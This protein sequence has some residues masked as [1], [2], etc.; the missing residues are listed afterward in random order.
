MLPLKS[1]SPRFLNIARR[2]GDVAQLV[3]CLPGMHKA[4]GSSYN[5]E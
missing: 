2:I 1:G 3:E 4:L 5:I